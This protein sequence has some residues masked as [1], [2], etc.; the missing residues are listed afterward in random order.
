MKA[1]NAKERA[2]AI[3]GILQN[4]E[5]KLTTADVKATLGDYIKLLQLKKELGD[6][7]PSKIEVTWVEPKGEK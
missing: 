3:E 4:F 6:E 2:E 1:K 5:E 7:A